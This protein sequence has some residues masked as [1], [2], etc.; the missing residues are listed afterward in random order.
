MLRATASAPA[1]L[2]VVP[3]LLT[4]LLVGCGSDKKSGPS[5]E[6]QS[7]R[8]EQ[9]QSDIRFYCIT[10][11]KDLMGAADPLGTLITAVDNLI[12]I[13]RSDPQATYRLA[14]V[15]KR[16]DKLGLQEVPI[17]K[18]LDQSAA[19]LDKKCGKYA[20]DQARRLKSV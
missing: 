16:G 4:A 20:A 11:R 6:V 10:G 3:L 17:K 12:K 19:T 1:R 15:D 5:N 7:L 8:I 18:L 2:L 9:F 14:R 13:Y